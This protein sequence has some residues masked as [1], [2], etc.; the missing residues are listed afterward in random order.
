MKSFQSPLLGGGS[1]GRR[2]DA[3]SCC[4]NCGAEIDWMRTE[5]GRYIPVDPEPVFVIEGEGDEHFYDDEL[6]AITGRLARPEEVQTKEQ[7]INALVGYVPHCRT[8]RARE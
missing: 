6:G 7:K 1:A 2:A 8:C 3:V 4:K 5:E